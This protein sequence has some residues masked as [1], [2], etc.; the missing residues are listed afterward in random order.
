MEEIT[1]LDHVTGVTPSVSATISVAR[2]SN[3]ESELSL[4]GK[5][6]YYFSTATDA[7]ERGRTFNTPLDITNNMARVCLIDSDIVDEFFY[8]VDPVGQNLYLNNLSFA[9]V[10][11]LAD[12]G[13]ESISEMVSGTTAIFWPLIPT[14]LK[15]NNETLVTSLTVYIDNANASDAVQ[16]SLENYL[17]RAVQL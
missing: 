15:M 4:S 13:G 10:G 11:V 12:S 14:V 8:G 17:D 6:D 16:T 2:G 7:V 9:V 3:Y 5:N 1:K